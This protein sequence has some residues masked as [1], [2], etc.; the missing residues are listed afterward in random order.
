MGL[1]LPAQVQPRLGPVW[2]INKSGSVKSSLLCILDHF[3]LLGVEGRI[4][5]EEY[6]EYPSFRNKVFRLV[7]QL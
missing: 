2:P 5:Y 3:F 6:T 4:A 7:F 1:L